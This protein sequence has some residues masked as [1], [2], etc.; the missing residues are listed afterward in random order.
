VLSATSSN[1]KSTVVQLCTNRRFYV[2]C[3]NS[4]DRDWAIALAGHH[5]H[6]DGPDHQEDFGRGR[7][8]RHRVV[9]TPSV[10]DF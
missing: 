8:D 6:S 1:R 4:A 10:R 3:R 2:A 7:G 5:L 9:D